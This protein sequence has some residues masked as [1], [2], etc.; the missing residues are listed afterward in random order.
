MAGL[1]YRCITPGAK[2]KECTV[3]ASEKFYRNGGHFVYRDSLG[4]IKMAISTT[5]TFYGWAEVPEGRGAGTSDDYWQA[6]STSISTIPIVVAPDAQ[7]LVPASTTVTT[8]MLGDAWDIYGGG[9]GT[10][11]YADVTAGNVDVI[12][13]DE[14][15]TYV[16]GGLTTDAVVH[17]NP[18]KFQ[19]D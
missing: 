14:I 15:G 16:A 2:T 12:I 7:Y 10:S 6:A 18:I 8:A 17:I 1:K 13:I 3:A 19:A 5:T 4:H 11:Q 9:S